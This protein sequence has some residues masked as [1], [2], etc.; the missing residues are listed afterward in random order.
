M[1]VGANDS[2]VI[3][4]EIVSE[5]V[6]ESNRGP[7]VPQAYGKLGFIVAIKLQAE[8]EDDD[9]DEDDDE[10]DGEDGDAELV[11]VALELSVPVLEVAVEDGFLEGEFVG[12]LSG[13]LPLF[14]PPP[15]AGGGP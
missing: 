7:S 4:T 11:V 10:D 6:I 5:R 3:V 2:D 8:A 1:D 15:P 12:L 13:S 9:D 14:P